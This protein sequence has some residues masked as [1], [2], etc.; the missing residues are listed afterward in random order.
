[1]VVLG[2]D[3]QTVLGLKKFFLRSQ[4]V[5]IGETLFAPY[6]IISSLEPGFRGLI[7]WGGKTFVYLF[8]IFVYVASAILSIKKEVKKDVWHLLFFLT[9]LYFL[10]MIWP[11]S[12][13]VH[14]TFAIPA[15]IFITAG[16]S[17]VDGKFWTKFAKVSLVI[18]ILIGFY[19][20]F[21]MRYYT[22]ET[23]YLLQTNETV[24]K[25]EKF[26]LDEKYFV[27][28]NSLSEL[29]NSLF[30]D[31]IVFA[32]PYM[33]MFYYLTDQTSPTY[34]LYT[35][36]SLLSPADQLEVIDELKAKNVDFV[37]FETWKEKDSPSLITKYILDNYKKVDEVWD[38]DILEKI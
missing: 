36:H 15:I 31:K 2:I 26:Y 20:T 35:V 29:K 28:A 11:L 23:P 4:S 21:F 12:D 25:D 19:K 16:F 1:L 17:L 22:F 37:I 14:L 24:I 30:K 7:K 33:P 27:I 10:A 38:Y 8:P 34:E 9:S 5:A 3:S 13:L 6:P 18:L 32:H